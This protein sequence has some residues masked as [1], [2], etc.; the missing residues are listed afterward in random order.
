[1]KIISKLA[2]LLVFSLLFSANVMAQKN[3]SK[4]A[5]KAF[6]NKE[7]FTSIDL[8]KKAY[9]KAKKKEDKAFIVF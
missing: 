1:M 5:D 6:D 7:Y 2:A 8:Y 9:T 3:F 4:D